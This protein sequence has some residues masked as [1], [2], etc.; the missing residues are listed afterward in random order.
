MNDKYD[1]IIFFILRVNL[2]N[3]RTKLEEKGSAVELTLPPT[4]S[5]ILKRAERQKIARWAI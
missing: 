3:R 2:I 5:L 4:P 1:K